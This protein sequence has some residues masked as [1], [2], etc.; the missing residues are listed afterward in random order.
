MKTIAFF[1]PFVPPEWIAAHGLRPQR[2]RLRPEDAR[3]AAACRGVCPF[4]GATVDRL[5]GDV[6]AAGVVH[7]TVC[8]QMRY[9]AALVREKNHLPTFLLNVPS[10]WQTREARHLYREELQRLGR[11]LVRLGGNAPSADVLS[12][13]RQ[14]YDKARSR[15][16]AG[17]SADDASGVPLAL[18][19]GPTPRGDG[20]IVDLVSRAGGRIVLDASEFGERTLPAPMDRRRA[21]DDPLG[22]LVDAY[23]GTIPDVSHRPNTRLYDWL[24]E[25][26]RRRPVRG[27]LFWRYVCCDLWHAELHRLRRWSPVPVLDVDVTHVDVTHDDSQHARLLGRIEAFLEMLQ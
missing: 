19:G 12:A 6:D 4:A 13:T 25:R 9:A 7:T 26:L 21:A 24:G 2:P 22:E 10:T 20:D 1:S 15:V 27:I 16:R 23:F 11:F 5:L 17:V 14:R 3:S 18:V 8:D